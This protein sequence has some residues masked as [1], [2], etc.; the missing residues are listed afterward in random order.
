LYPSSEDMITRGIKTLDKGS[1][2]TELS[3]P[4]SNKNR[5]AL[6]AEKRVVA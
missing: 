6:V 4:P 1:D 3:P 5:A 2:V